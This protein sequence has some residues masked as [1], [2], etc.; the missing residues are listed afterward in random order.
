MRAPVPR[1]KDPNMQKCYEGALALA[2]DLAGEFF[3]T[4]RSI[5]VPAIAVRFGTGTTVLRRPRTPFRE[6]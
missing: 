6:R 2:E 4:A 1:Y 3:T 5:A